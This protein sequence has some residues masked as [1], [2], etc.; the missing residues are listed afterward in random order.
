MEI[1]IEEKI[2]PRK[3]P[4]FTDET[5]DNKNAVIRGYIRGGRGLLRRET[6]PHVTDGTSKTA[7][8]IRV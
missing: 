7:G 2:W 8:V 1:P 6:P 3:H 5:T 4:P